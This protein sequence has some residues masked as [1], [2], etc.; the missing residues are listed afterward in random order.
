MN[1][2]SFY[3]YCHI[4]DYLMPK[5]ATGEQLPVVQYLVLY[6]RCILVTAASIDL[7]GSC[8]ECS[9]RIEEFVVI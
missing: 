3:K 9:I 1:Q 5:V 4:S 8:N 2:S 7:D 6:D